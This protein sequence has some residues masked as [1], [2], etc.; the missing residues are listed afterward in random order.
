MRIGI[1]AEYWTIDGDG[2]L[3]PSG[4]LA[5]E[6]D[7]VDPEFVAPLVEVKTPPCE[8]VAAVTAEFVSRLSRALD[9][10]QARGK[11][12]A[13]LG[14]PLGDDRADI[15]SDARIDV[16]RAILGDD[17][18]HAAHCAGTHVH[19]EQTAVADQ[20]RALTAADPAFALVNTAPYYRGRR[21]ATCARPEVYRR[22]CYRTLPTHGRLWRYPDSAAEWRA[23]RDDRFEA[24]VREA[25]AAG[26]DPETVAEAFTPH[27]AVWSPVRLRD[28]LGT[29]EWR[30]PDTAPPA[31]VLRL[32]AD[33][34]R[35]VERAVEC[36]TR[37]GADGSPGEPEESEQSPVRLPSFET[38]QD[39]VET[40]IEHGC[41]AQ[42]VTRYLRRLGFDT[43]AYR[44]VG[45]R[46]DGRTSLDAEE[47]RSLRVE[48]ADRLE[49]EV[50]RLS[51]G[52]E[53]PEVGGQQP[54][55]VPG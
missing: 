23:W 15:R 51:D 13:P 38:L 8:S 6:C 14:T 5:A 42:E 10:A 50:Q 52:S 3:V 40:A 25:T 27:D 55:A 49:R 47:V 37:L 12:L 45:A 22:R 20:L 35:L 34:V 16:Q 18:R 29:V 39:Y 9:A 48:Y 31:D 33:V 36:G 28:D 53:P 43:D 30:A 26:V 7:A 44:P 2:E 1:E 11:R 24:F 17:L 19:V 46:L 32:V 4:D 21:V 41:E 54:S